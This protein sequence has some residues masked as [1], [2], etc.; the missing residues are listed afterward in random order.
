MNTFNYTERRMIYDSQMR[1]VYHGL[2]LKFPPICSGKE[3]PKYLRFHIVS[4]AVNQGLLM[5]C[6]IAVLELGSQDEI[7]K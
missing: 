1:V 4:R 5:V 7:G 3:R 2:S 6:D